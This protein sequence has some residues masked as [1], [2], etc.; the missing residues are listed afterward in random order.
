MLTASLAFGLVYGKW[1]LPGHLQGRAVFFVPFLSA[2]YLLM[3]KL[4]LSGLTARASVKHGAERGRFWRAR[5]V[6]RW[7]FFVAALWTAPSGWLA[8]ALAVHPLQ[9]F[10]GKWETIGYV[11]N[12]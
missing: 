4:V 11:E 12:P 1:G 3:G 7:S 5:P 9:T 8:I 10:Q 6:C 2:V